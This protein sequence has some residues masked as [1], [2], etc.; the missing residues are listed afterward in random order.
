VVWAQYGL[1]RD[2]KNVL[3]LGKQRIILHFVD[4]RPSQSFL[5]AFHKPCLSSHELQNEN[6]P[7]KI[8]H[9]YFISFNNDNNNENCNCKLAKTL[10]HALIFYVMYTSDNGQ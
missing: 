3:Y 5:A 7:L 4:K 10:T 6:T 2:I 1:L 8:L 9:L